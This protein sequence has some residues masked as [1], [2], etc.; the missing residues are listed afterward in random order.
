MVL[1]I[2]FY[3]RYDVVCG[4]CNC[5]TALFIQRPTMSFYVSNCIEW[6]KSQDKNLMGE[7]V[8][9]FDSSFLN[10]CSS[11]MSS[12]VADVM[13]NALTANAGIF[14]SGR[15]NMIQAVV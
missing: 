15:G 4:C 1:Q 2:F 7:G 8:L 13:A 5:N 14:P 12:D 3:S 6:N 10:N 11:N 9:I